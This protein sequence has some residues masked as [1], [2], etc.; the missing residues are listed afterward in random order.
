MFC[1]LA[2]PAGAEAEMRVSSRFLELISGRSAH[3]AE[4]Q[5]QNRLYLCP[6]GDVFG[7]R[8]RQ[9]GVTV[10]GY[11][12]GDEGRAAR[13]AGLKKR[14]IIEAVNGKEVLSASDLAAKVEAAEGEIKLTV[15]RGG[16]TLTITA[17][18]VRGEDG[19]KLGVTV[20]DSAAGIGT[21]TFRDP[22]NGAFCG[23]GHGICDAETGEVIGM[24]SGE[25]TGV[26]LGGIVRGES[27][28]PGELRGVLR[29]DSRGLLTEN[30]ECGVFGVLNTPVDKSAAI[31]V[32]H[33]NEVHDGAAQIIC[34]LSDGNKA[35][36]SVEIGEINYESEGTKSF[37]V[38]VT[39]DALLRISGGIV[40]GMS[41]SPIIQDGRLIGAVTHVLIADPQRGFGIFIENMLDAMPQITVRDG[42]AA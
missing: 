30:S 7:I 22:E 17:T 15:R 12:D 35:S 23:L 39:D 2:A 26:L 42:I 9:K 33:K 19:A 18:P 29:G 34:T 1:S 11:A 38:R 28:K 20:R 4:A 32:A 13:D 31:P 5:E 6:G 27:G 36:Y 24:K 10:T 25:V 3:A 37:T 40:R 41:G 8:M 14:D 16:E 21:I